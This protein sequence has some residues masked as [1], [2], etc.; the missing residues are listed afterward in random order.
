ML[1]AAKTV[2]RTSSVLGQESSRRTLL[3]AWEWGYFSWRVAAAEP[4]AAR[5][6]RLA[7]G[8][9]EMARVGLGAAGTT[10]AGASW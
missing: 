8:A 3:N 5:W 10:T 4:W 9:W 7:A 6:Q 2:G 1:L